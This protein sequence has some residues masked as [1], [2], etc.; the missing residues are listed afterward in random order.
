[1]RR[2]ALKDSLTCAK[3]GAVTRLLQ[4]PGAGRIA[5]LITQATHSK[6]EKGGTAMKAI[7]NLT[8]LVGLSVA[9]IA[10]AA[11]GAM[12][13]KLAITSF[14]GSFT[15]PL[16]AQW[17]AMALPAGDYNLS[18]GQPFKG[19]IQVVTVAGKAEGSPR[20]MVLIK[21]R[22]Q[23]SA[24]KNALV[25]AREGHTLV[26]RALELPAIGESVDFAPPHGVKVRAWVV[27]GKGNHNAKTHLAEV[28]IPIERVPVTP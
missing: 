4:R 20:G 22:S 13:Q 2:S 17:A 10:L 21:A 18:Y 8:I 9:L 23:T 26:V 6:S 24:S 15:L 16:D 5:Q 12:A 11:T 27:A 1:M 14:N 3:V 7:R 19:G 25:C 28:P